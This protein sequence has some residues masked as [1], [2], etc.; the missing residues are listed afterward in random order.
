MDRRDG[1]NSDVDCF[2]R[3]LVCNRETYLM[4]IKHFLHVRLHCARVLTLYDKSK[5]EVPLPRI[6]RFFAKI[7][8]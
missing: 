2:D 1:Q 5:R 3:L 4:F 7:L 8:Y 6:A